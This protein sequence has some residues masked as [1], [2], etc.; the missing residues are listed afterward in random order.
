MED[1][2][3]AANVEENDAGADGEDDAVDVDTN[4]KDEDEAATGATGAHELSRSKSSI[5]STCALEVS[6]W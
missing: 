2:L 4:A 3:R 1:E 6:A 5:S